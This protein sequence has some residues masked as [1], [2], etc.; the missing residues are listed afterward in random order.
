MSEVLVETAAAAAHPGFRGDTADL[1]AFLSFAAAERYGSTHSLSTA[2]RLLRKQHGVD[3]RPFWDFDAAEAE[4]EQDR[5]EL[6]RIW[7]EGGPLAEAATTAAAAIR[8]DAQL[9]ALTRDFPALADRLDDLAAIA[10]WAAARNV[11]VRLTYR[12]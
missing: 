5:Q 10:H 6:A 11:R 9:A 4:D 12:L 2:A 8:G 7:Q 3:T 1:L